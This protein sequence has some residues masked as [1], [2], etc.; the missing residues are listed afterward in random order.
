ML[1]PEDES[2]LKRRMKNRLLQAGLYQKHATAFYVGV[3]F[4]LVITPWPVGLGL[5][6]LG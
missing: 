5:A 3:K 4:V 2:K 1:M 6:R